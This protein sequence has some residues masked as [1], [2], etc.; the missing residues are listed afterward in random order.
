MDRPKAIRGL[1]E[2]NWMGL[3]MSGQAR[4]KGRIVKKGTWAKAERSGGT[5]QK[6]TRRRDGDTDRTDSEVTM[7]DPNGGERRGR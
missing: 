3:V 1:N 6:L 2:G 7:R 5:S 4:P